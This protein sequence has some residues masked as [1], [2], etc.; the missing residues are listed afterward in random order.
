MY[1]EASPPSTLGR[2]DQ[3]VVLFDMSLFDWM[4][5]LYNRCAAEQM[6]PLALEVE[7]TG[8]GLYKGGVR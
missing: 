5:W 7:A 4:W 8:Q 6:R 1:A 2:P 3:T